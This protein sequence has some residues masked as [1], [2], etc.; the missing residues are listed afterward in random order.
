[1]AALLDQPLGEVT[2]ASVKLGQ[3]QIAEAFCCVRLI[4]MVA[5]PVGFPGVTFASRFDIVSALKPDQR[6]RVRV[7]RRPSALLQ[8]QP[9]PHQV[10][11]RRPSQQQVQQAQVDQQRRKH[12]GVPLAVHLPHR[13]LGVLQCADRIAWHRDQNQ[14]R[15]D[16]RTQRRV[17]TRYLKCPLQVAG[18]QWNRSVIPLDLSQQLEP[19]RLQH[20]G[21]PIHLHP[22][23]EPPGIGDIPRP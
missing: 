9:S 17:I 12:Q 13:P 7:G 21:Q 11:P 8:R 5:R 2:A 4:A 3:C 1:M 23:S 19:L 6:N 20:R 18:R 10:G 22:I 15:G 14:P 16:P